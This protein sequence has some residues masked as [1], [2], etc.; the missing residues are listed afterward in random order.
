MYR[1]GS[2]DRRLGFR[3]QNYS[4]DTR[5]DAPHAVVA[6][7]R[8]VEI[9]RRIECD[10]RGEREFGLERGPSFAPEP[11]MPVACQRSDDHPER[12]CEYASR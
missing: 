9:S 7:I 5:R 12:P 2:E 1:V 11:N 10:A 6:A 8:K 3:T 4:D